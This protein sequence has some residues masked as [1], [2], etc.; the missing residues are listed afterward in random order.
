MK[1]VISRTHRA[2]LALVGLMLLSGMIPLW[3]FAP[4]P[5]PIGTAV[6]PRDLSKVQH[7]VIIMQENRSFDHYFGTYP[8][9]DGIPSGICLPNPIRGGCDAPFHDPSP[10]NYEAGHDASSYVADL[11]AGAM[12]GF[13]QEAA[14]DWCGTGHT[15]PSQS[16]VNPACAGSEPFA[17]MSYHTGQ[18]I[19][20][21]W[22]YAQNFVLQD[23]LF[24]PVTSWSL[25]THLYL[26]SNW[27]ATCP[28]SG[29]P[30]SCSTDLISPTRAITSPFAWT[31]I[32]YLLHQSGVSWGYYV[33]PGTPPD[34]L[35][36][37]AVCGGQ[38]NAS[39]P[40]VWNPL[41]FFSTVHT[42][43]EIGN[44]RPLTDFIT[45]A[46]SGTLPAVAWVVPSGRYS[47][48]YP[49]LVS[50]GQAYVTYLVNALMSGPEWGSTA[51]F[52][53]WD[54][55][56]GFYDHVVPPVVDSQGYGFRVP[57]LVISPYAKKGYIDH[58]TLS[59]DA[60]NKFIEDVFLGG[61]RLDPATDG[62]PD[63]RP[64]VR[65]SVPALGDLANDFD[66]TQ[67][68]RP[69]LLLP[70]VPASVPGFAIT[71]TQGSHGQ[72]VTVSGT[73]FAAGK[74]V[75]LYWGSAAVPP[76][77]PAITSTLTDSTGTL[78]IALRVPAATYGAHS[79]EVVGASSGRATGF[80]FWVVPSAVLAASRGRA[81]T[82]NVAY[83]TGFGHNETVTVRWGGDQGPAIGLGTSNASGVLGPANGISFTVPLS[84][85]G[86]YTVVVGGPQSGEEAANLFQITP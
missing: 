12:N 50:D 84:P 41:P 23:H 13:V 29:D 44:V 85:T 51:I 69:P 78:A 63:P 58:Q 14:R 5:W 36:G 25:P 39:T 57:G 21:Y 15:Y 71:P 16:A 38:Q 27:S 72:T 26:V 74:R 1:V 40:S 2:R 70:P 4:V 77:V 31:D 62:R 35:S 76:T 8:G 80:P 68:P 37:L 59:F 24:A 82:A 18:E 9:A 83:G 43:G 73:H 46:I 11:N 61:Q 67:P 3:R 48:H 45:A 47:E 22:A 28:I 52:L 10:L 56:G 75:N 33:S 86:N 30:M 81:G 17:V 6:R 65:E 49:A 54:D 66:F 79:V 19:P 7:V 53:S 20:N 60:F 64:T 42:D 32:T 55:W 34:C